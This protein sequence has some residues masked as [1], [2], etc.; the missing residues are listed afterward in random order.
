MR[1]F[2]QRLLAAKKSVRLFAEE[3]DPAFFVDGYLV[4]VCDEYVLL[5][6]VDEDGAF[7]GYCLKRTENIFRADT[8]SQ[9]LQALEK[10][11]EKREIADPFG[12]TEVTLKDVFSRLAKEKILCSV[13]LFDDADTITYGFI[14]D[15]SETAV[16]M[17]EI[18]RYGKDDGSVCIRTENVTTVCFGSKREQKRFELFVRSSE[19]SREFL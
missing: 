16:V 10:P 6:S 19:K 11:I 1:K 4:R 18:D 9:Y 5:L 8:D 7:D 15:V 13:E 17:N 3:G 12:G 14:K 2:L